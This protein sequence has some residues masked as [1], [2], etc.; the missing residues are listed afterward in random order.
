MAV[1]K[2][3][4]HEVFDFLLLYEVQLVELLTKRHQVLRAGDSQKPLPESLVVEEDDVPKD[5]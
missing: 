2:D 5:Q 3:F 4:E 1:L